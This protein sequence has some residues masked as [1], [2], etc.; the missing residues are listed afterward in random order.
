MARYVT[1]YMMECRTVVGDP[2][3][4]STATMIPTVSILMVSLL[5]CPPREYDLDITFTRPATPVVVAVVH[6]VVAGVSCVCGLSPFPTCRADDDDEEG[7]TE[8]LAGCSSPRVTPPSL[9][10][11]VLTNHLE[12]KSSKDSPTLWTGE[13]PADKTGA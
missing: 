1:R 6:A 2:P 5:R 9:A 12:T 13:S 10:P 7:M 4:P 3:T 8:A 11:M